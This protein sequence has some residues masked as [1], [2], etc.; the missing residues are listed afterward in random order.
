MANNI[1][2][3]EKPYPTRS[4]RKTPFDEEK[5]E[6][7][8]SKKKNKNIHTKNN[9]AINKP[10]CGR[11]HR[12]FENKNSLNQHPSDCLRSGNAESFLKNFSRKP[13]NPVVV[14]EKLIIPFTN[15]SSCSG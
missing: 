2:N 14:V 10:H 15:H 9:K 13:D 5:W 3:D 7:V 11:C 4:Q 6:T 8:G 12:I 1:I